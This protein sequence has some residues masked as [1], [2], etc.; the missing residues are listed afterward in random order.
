[1]GA[2]RLRSRFVVILAIVVLAS[3]LVPAHRA[4]RL[5]PAVALRHD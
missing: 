4:A 3:T 1:V 2:A 5:D